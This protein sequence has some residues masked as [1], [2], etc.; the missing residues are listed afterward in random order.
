MRIT[1]LP[2][3]VPVISHFNSTSSYPKFAVFFI[4]IGF[5]G[6]TYTLVA[7]KQSNMTVVIMSLQTN[8]TKHINP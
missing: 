7:G 1:P 6:V 4:E 8:A 3:P 2:Y 5:L